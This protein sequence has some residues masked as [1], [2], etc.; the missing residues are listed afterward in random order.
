MSD[1]GP[2]QLT[3]QATKNNLATSRHASLS[4]TAHHISCSVASEDHL[5][6]STS[7]GAK[8]SPADVK[9]PDELYF[10]GNNVL[11]LLN[12]KCDMV[13]RAFGSHLIF[14]RRQSAL[15]GTSADSNSA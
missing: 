11:D 9:N 7:A 10:N 2:E 12:K 3:I 6:I 4:A 13:S 14:C 15:F 5:V 1:R 8:I